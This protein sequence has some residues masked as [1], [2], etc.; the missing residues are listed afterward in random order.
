MD[1]ARNTECI[2][3]NSRRISGIITICWEILDPLKIREHAKSSCLPQWNRT[4][5]RTVTKKSQKSKVFDNYT[6]C[7]NK[8]DEG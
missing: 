8:H 5:E 2:N 7:K 4:N 3:K 1:T 6:P